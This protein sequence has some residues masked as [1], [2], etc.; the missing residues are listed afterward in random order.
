VRG[1]IISQGFRVYLSSTALGWRKAGMPE[2]RKAG[3]EEG[4]M[5]GRQGFR[6]CGGSEGTN[7]VTGCPNQ[8]I[9]WPVL[10]KERQAGR[11]AGRKAGRK[12]GWRQVRLEGRQ[13]GRKALSRMSGRQEGRKAHTIGHAAHST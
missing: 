8:E 3:R 5:G 4:R 2:G 12:A 10:Y 13:E 11:L 1:E 6:I 7:F 9:G